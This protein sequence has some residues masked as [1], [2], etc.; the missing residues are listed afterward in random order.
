MMARASTKTLLPL[1]RFFQLIGMNPLHANQVEVVGHESRVCG[2]PLVQ[3][4]WQ[5]ADT[6]GREEIAQ[7][8]SDAE[9]AME[10]WLGYSPLPRW[11]VDER[12][13]QL[14]GALNA[15][16][17]NQAIQ[18]QGGFLITGGI[19]AKVALQI[20]ASIVYT[21]SDGDL[22]KELATITVA[23]LPTYVTN[24]EEIAIYYPGKFADDIWEIKPITVTITGTTATITCFR[25]QLVNEVPMEVLDD[26]RA[27][28]G[29]DDTKFLTL[30]DVYRHYNDP[31]RQ[32]QFLWEGGCESCGTDA[33]SYSTQWGCLLVRDNRLG[34]VSASPSDW[35][36]T[37]NTFLATIFTPCRY[38]DRTRLWYR[39][40]YRDM[41]LSTPHKTMA[42]RL[43]RAV[44]YYALS[45]ISR[46]LCGCNAI[47]NL[48]QWWATDMA[49]SHS[50]RGAAVTTAVSRRQLENP[51]GTTRGALYAWNIVRQLKLGESA[52]HA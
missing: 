8:I 26:V 23:G 11:Y 13:T 5:L 27:V 12:N 25:H 30:V 42:S 4:G 28:S 35:D 46:P 33:C 18:T 45:L 47:K 24:K 3:Y 2:S 41:A 39:A 38:P 48:S 1:D 7:A 52:P 50:T 9:Q 49:V 32:V 17:R 19:E 20:N 10:A 15:F 21:D 34:L 22:Y 16:N 14:V 44:A 6:V 31:Q 37:A 36:S 29:T 43:E 51:F 40:G